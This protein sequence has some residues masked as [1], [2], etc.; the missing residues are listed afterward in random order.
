M[1]DMNVAPSNRALLVGVI[2]PDALTAA[3]H[4]TGWVDL[5]LGHNVLATIA[6]GDLGT[7]ATVNAKL[8]QATSSGGA[9][10]KDITGKAITELTDIDS[11]NDA[12]KQAVINCRSEELDVE[13]DFAFVRLTITVGVATSD[14]FGMLQRF[15]DRYQPGTPVSSVVETVTN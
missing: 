15:D 6:V 11:P 1:G 4:S 13:N 9:G 14:G 3:A 12:N 2:D 8:E 5:G 7:D 10:V